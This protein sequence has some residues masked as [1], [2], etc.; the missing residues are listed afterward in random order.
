[1]S[2]DVSGFSFAPNVV[3]AAFAV[4]AGLVFLAFAGVHLRARPTAVRGRA[5]TLACIVAVVFPLFV[6]PLGKLL[7]A[8]LLDLPYSWTDVGLLAVFVVV[9]SGCAWYFRGWVLLNVRTE[10]LEDLIEHTCKAVDVPC[11]PTG[12]DKGPVF[13]IGT[14]ARDL[15]IRREPRSRYASVFFCRSSGLPWLGAFAGELRREVTSARTGRF[16]SRAVLFLIIG[17]ICLGFAVILFAPGR[18]GLV[19]SALPGTGA[20]YP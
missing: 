11:Q 14:E 20:G 10:R 19:P 5:I 12:R 4:L 15:F 13:R 1:M 7:E 2:L 8:F 16:Y 17:L 3:V 18:L 6:Y 9:A